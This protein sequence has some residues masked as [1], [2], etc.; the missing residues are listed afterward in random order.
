[1]PEHTAYTLDVPTEPP[2]G[3]VAL[4]CTNKAW[5]CTELGWF[6]ARAGAPTLF[7][8]GAVAWPQLLLTRA[9]VR[10]IYTPDSAPG[11]APEVVHVVDDEEGPIYAATSDER[12]RQWVA[13][14][15]HEH[16]ALAVT[17]VEVDR[18]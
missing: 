17:A 14:H 3:S 2:V 1:M 8:V 11:S 15:L 9:P 5:Q 6:A 10:V 16:K 4:D 7:A 18:G 13:D 12:A